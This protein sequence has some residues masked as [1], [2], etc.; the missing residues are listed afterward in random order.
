MIL[1]GKNREAALLMVEE[2]NKVG[3]DEMI[4]TD[5]LV[6]VC[7]MELEFLDKSEISFYERSVNYENGLVSTKWQQNN[8]HYLKEVLLPGQI[9]VLLQ[10]F[11]VQRAL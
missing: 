3:I 5:P 4:W 8:I 10:E 9:H 11:P 6:P 7:Q 1:D 2:G